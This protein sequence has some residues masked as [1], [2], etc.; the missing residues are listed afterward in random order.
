MGAVKQE[1][2]AEVKDQANDD[3]PADI[4]TEMKDEESINKH[5][6]HK[7]ET[8]TIF[9]SEIKQYEEIITYA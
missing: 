7:E 3:Q 4:D 1:M 6:Y 9:R 2:A 5:V 8:I